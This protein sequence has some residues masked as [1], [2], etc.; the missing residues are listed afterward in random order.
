M[1]LPEPLR[2]FK[3][4]AEPLL[5]KLE[6]I[7]GSM[8][9]PILYSMN[10]FLAKPD[11]DSIYEALS[12]LGKQPKI[13]VI[14]F[15]SGGDPDQAYVIGI[16][17]QEF[18]GEKLTL[19]IP[20]YA[21]S[22][23]TLLACAADEVLMLPPSELGPIDPVVES[24]ET[25]RYIPVL[26]LLELVELLGKKGLGGEVVKEVLGRIPVTEL[27]DYTRL[28]EHMVSLAEKLLKRRMFKNEP[29]IAR[30]I[31][32][33]LCKEYKSHGAAITL[34]DIK[35][36]GL[37]LADAPKDI[38]DVV[39]SLHRL[40]VETVMEYESGFPE[41]APIEA[42]DFNVGRGIV[43]CTR[44]TEDDARSAKETPA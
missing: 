25:K 44:R 22:A 23:A 42:F 10:R 19:I 30:S 39:W 28:T 2:H 12:S 11:T 33:K 40:W 35:E 36:L 8:A 21:K 4:R 9:V 34:T 13:D 32:E 24:P 18:A 7:R 29:E 1:S 16:M 6:E 3:E 15:S 5:V 37:K 41:G 14:L 43:F 27:G 17:L 20:R 26:S 31:A 38:S